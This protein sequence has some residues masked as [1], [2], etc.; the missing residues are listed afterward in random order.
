MYSIS[1][2]FFP[3][4]KG[5]MVGYIEAVTGVGLILGPLI[6]SV[7]Y[8]IGGYLFI[9][10]AFGSM[11]LLFSFFIK[12]IFDDRI[13]KIYTAM[14]EHENE[15]THS[16]AEW[17]N[18]QGDDFA[19]QETPNDINIGQCLFSD[20]DSFSAPLQVETNTSAEDQETSSL[21]P[22][23]V[24]FTIGTFELL[25][26]PRFVFGCL[27][28]SLGYFLYGFMEPVLAFRAHEFDLSPV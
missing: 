24:H 10:Y 27:S 12:T 4:H 5:A 13:D 3:G 18:L 9:F 21:E 17:A 6:G 16:R 14:S 22:F 25:A 2:N 1:T 20:D 7:L 26:Y 8:S 11:F 19:R 28:A 15:S 23:E